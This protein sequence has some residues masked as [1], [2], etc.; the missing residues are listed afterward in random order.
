MKANYGASMVIGAIAGLVGALAIFLFVAGM[1]GVSSLDPAFDTGS[2]EPVFSISASA[3]WSMTLLAGIAVGTILAIATKAVARV[4]DPDAA[5]NSLWIIAP[6][7]ATVG[8]VIGIVVFPLGVTV[9][10]TIAE[11]TATVTVT[12]MVG[13][14]A[15]AGLLG[16]ASVVWLSYVLSRPPVL[17]PDPELLAT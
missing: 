15:L 17:E 16:G 9:V 8:A 12:D 10:G 13:M 6:V 3:L 4:I 2:V 14:V 7:G 5:A 11:G 1:G